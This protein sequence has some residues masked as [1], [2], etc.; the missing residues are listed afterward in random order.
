MVFSEERSGRGR[1]Y[2]SS[3]RSASDGEPI[4]AAESR[5]LDLQARL[6]PMTNPFPRRNHQF[7]SSS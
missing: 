7:L 6:I 2:Y 3:P 1:L 5:C 4:S